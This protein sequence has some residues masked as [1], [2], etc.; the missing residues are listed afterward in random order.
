MESAPLNLFALIPG[1]LLGLTGYVVFIASFQNIFNVSKRQDGIM[2][3]LASAVLTLAGVVLVLKSHG[4]TFDVAAIVIGVIAVTLL[5]AL[6][7]LKIF[8]FPTSHGDIA[9]EQHTEG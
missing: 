1:V 2:M 8:G 4:H 9:N 6:G 3:A 5:A 7:C